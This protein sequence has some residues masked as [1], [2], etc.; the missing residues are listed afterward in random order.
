MHLASSFL[1]AEVLSSINVREKAALDDELLYFANAVKQRIILTH[2]LAG[3]QR[4]FLLCTP[5]VVR[6]THT[7][8]CQF[9]I[10][11]WCCVANYL[12]VAAPISTIRTPTVVRHT[13]T[14]VCAVQVFIAWCC[15][16]WRC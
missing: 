16:A 11:A 12:L 7:C 14:P 10:I 6:R 1:C 2:S 9:S 8:V 4:L 3:R 13:H 15:V 5:I